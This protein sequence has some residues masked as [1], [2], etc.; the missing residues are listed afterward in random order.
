MAEERGHELTLRVVPD[1][2]AHEKLDR[3]HRLLMELN[4]KVE[5]MAG[6]LDALTAQVARN[7]DVETSAIVLLNGIKA[8]LDAAIL[9]GDPTKLTALAA[10]LGTSA[11][12]LAAA[13][14]ANTPAVP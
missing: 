14:V 9:S 11:D 4:R 5:T 1:A 12:A 8:Q 10:T 13:V 2:G 7:T 3:L 6:E